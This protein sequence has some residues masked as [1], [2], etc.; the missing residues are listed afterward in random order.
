MKTPINRFSN[1][2]LYKQRKT[3]KKI[4]G[5]DQHRII[6]VSISKDQQRHIQRKR[7]ITQ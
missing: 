1:R 7:L 2:L 3:N 4:K 6:R 5:E